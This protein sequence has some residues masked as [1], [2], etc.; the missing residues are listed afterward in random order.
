MKW[1]PRGYQARAVERAE[2]A[3]CLLAIEMGLGKT[4]I[5]LTAAANLL[6]RFSALRVLV[7]APKRVADATWPA[8]IAKWDHLSGLRVCRLNKGPKER[9]AA[10]FPMRHDIYIIGR[11]LVPWLVKTFKHPDGNRWPFDMVIIDEST[12][13]KSPDADR[14]RALRAV[15]KRMAHVLCLTGTPISNSYLDLWGQMFLVDGG[16]SLGHSYTSY[17]LSHFTSDYMGFKYELRPGA[18]KLIEEAVRSSVLSLRAEDYLELPDVITVDTKVDLPEHAKKVYR[19]LEKQGLSELSD[20][21]EVTALSAA[22]VANKLL[23]VASG[24]VY[25][26]ID[27]TAPQPKS[28]DRVTHHLHDAKMDALEDI[29]ESTAENVVVV[30]AFQA[31]LARLQ[32]R[33]GAV[34][35]RERGAVDR[36]NAGK[37][38]VLALHPASGGYGLNLQFGGRRLVWYTLTWSLEQWLQT[39]A[40]L[41]R[42]GQT[43]Q[44]FIHRLLATSTIE[45]RIVDVLSGRHQDLT[46]L[47]VSMA[48]A[49]ETRRSAA[50]RLASAAS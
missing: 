26:D 49:R 21:E 11:E 10:L 22:A 36:W 6:A 8:E 47:M 41:Q 4:A 38:R 12:S 20:A 50:P 5:A 17:R 30:Y 46:E 40:R 13:F 39:I 45:E 18:K 35:V 7:I 33:F 25:A 42:T 43:Q 23:Q 3:S 27:A 24:F 34:D 1:I 31:D 29:L 32:K 44:V 37:I 9:L 28:A 14:F 48:H 15:R 2:Q 19:D 16:A